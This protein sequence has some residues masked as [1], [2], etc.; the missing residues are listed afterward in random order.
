MPASSP[1]PTAMANVEADGIT[2]ELR[3]ALPTMPCTKIVDVLICRL[4]CGP[5]R[6]N[7]CFVLTS[8]PPPLLLKPDTSPLM[9]SIGNSTGIFSDASQPEAP[10]PVPPGALNTYEYPA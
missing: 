5:S 7:I 4:T 3:C 9:P 1:P 6:K 10:P 8:G 2:D